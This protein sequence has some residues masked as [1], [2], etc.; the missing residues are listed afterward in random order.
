LKFSDLKLDPALQR[1][2]V[3]MGFAEP[4]AIQSAAL[5]P[6]LA[7][8]DI[9]A[10]AMTGSGKTAAFVLP[11]LNRLIGDRS[12]STRALVVTPTRE[13]AAQVDQHFRDLGRHTAIRSA[14]VFGG[15]KPGPQERALKGGVDV[16]VACPGRLLD[17]MRQPWLHFDRLE[18]LVLDEADRMLDMGFLPDIKRILARIPKRRQTMLFSATLPP[19]IVA[20]SRDLLI[21][22]VRL[23][24]ERRPAPA[25]GIRQVALSVPEA[26]KKG[27]L[28]D[29]LRDE[30][31]N[32]LVFT[33]TKHRANSLARY[34]E[35]AGIPCDR[36]HGNRSQ[37]Q[38]ES[39][40]A[41]FKAGRIRV[42]VATDVASRGIDVEALSHVINFDVP[43]QPEDY[44]HRVGR[45][46]RA[47]ATGEALTFVS[48]AEE[49]G[50]RAIERTV[51]RRIDRHPF[52]GGARSAAGTE[53]RLAA[54][55]TG[56]PAD[57]VKGHVASRPT[58]RRRRR[59]SRRKASPRAQAS[60]AA[61]PAVPAVS[62]S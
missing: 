3:D 52:G 49:N 11:I 33:R 56:K 62:A 29:V 21:H 4:T 24:V 5:P 37:P 30:V 12:G 16:V 42:L 7:G 55:A 25:T 28:L 54:P 31:K 27:L 53:S 50:L 34:L 6:A 47:G 36:I 18:V 51:G 57:A 61:S 13:L 15:V 59:G 35:K 40:L 60:P 17:H 2:V 8:Q 43:S 58:G 22:P 19:P 45:T 9:L 32:A 39:A 44:V 41:A 14:V 48:P 10:S 26:H 38:R 1:G 20:L 23:G 46:A